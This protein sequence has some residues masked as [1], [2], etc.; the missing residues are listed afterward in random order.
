[1]FVTSAVVGTGV[2]V[3]RAQLAAKTSV[4]VGQSGV[5]KSRLLNA[6]V[7]GAG[8]ST[9]EVSRKVRRGRH[10][11]RHV[12]LISISDGFIA[13]T[14]G[15]SLLEPVKVSPWELSA[16]FEEIHAVEHSCRFTGCAVKDAVRDGRIPVSRYENY[17]TML[18]E[19]ETESRRY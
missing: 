9:Q 3:L 17:L 1:L 4:M 5:G 8:R 14:P 19:A 7:P 18:S 15:F 11:T 13:D 16:F 2:D 6:L 10:T 12:E